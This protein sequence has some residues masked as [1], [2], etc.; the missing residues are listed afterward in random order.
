MIRRLAL[1]A[2]YR[3]DDTFEHTERVGALAAA[4]AEELGLDVE[5]IEVLRLAAPLHDVGKIGI[6]DAI[7]LKPGK[8]TPEEYDVMKTHTVLGAR[9]L[10]GSGAPVLE[11]G[12]RIAE[13]HHERWDG[14]GYP[15][16]LGGEEIP[17]AG[18][19]VAVADVF[20]AL[21]HERPYKDAWPEEDALAEIAQGA[22]GQFDPLVVAAFLAVQNRKRAARNGGP[23]AA[24][25]LSLVP[26]P[27]VGTALSRTR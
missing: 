21:T 23:G 1:A 26:R 20:D 4:V 12:C 13:T 6:P 22:G 14:N 19:I 11:L 3:D 2:E 24:T 17:L 8:L 15:N 18:R 16:A 5:D 7:L 27:H 10:T 9:L 25:E